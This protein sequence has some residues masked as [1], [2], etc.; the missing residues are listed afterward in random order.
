MQVGELL[1]LITGTARWRER[2]FAIRRDRLQAPKITIHSRILKSRLIVAPQQMHVEMAAW[3]L[4]LIG[5]LKR[6]SGT[7]QC[8]HSA[9]QS[10]VPTQ[11]GFRLPD[12]T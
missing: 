2:K 8:P 12:L 4:P 7:Q 6:T 10:K 3:Q 5:E 1:P 9:M 11:Y